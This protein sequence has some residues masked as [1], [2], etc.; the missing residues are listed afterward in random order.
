MHTD[1]N[2]DDGDLYSRT[3]YTTDKERH[4]RQGASEEKVQ[5]R[6][7]ADGVYSSAMTDLS[8][9][10]VSSKNVTQKDF[11]LQS[12][13][14]TEMSSCHLNDEKTFAKINTEN[15]FD[16][17]ECD[18]ETETGEE[19]DY[20]HLVSVVE[21]DIKNISNRISTAVIDFSFSCQEKGEENGSHCNH[22]DFVP[23]EIILKIFSYFDPLDLCKQIS[24]VSKRWRKLAYDVSLW[25]LLDLNWNPHL[26][27]VNLCWIIKR[28]GCIRK[29]CLQSRQMLSVSEVSVFTEFCPL[30]TDVDLG[31]CSTCSADILE[32]FVLNCENLERINVEGCHMVADECCEVLAKAKRLKHLNFSHCIITDAGLCHLA[33]NLSQIVSLN[34]DGIGW[35]NDKS[36]ITLVEHHHENLKWLD[37]DGAELT[38]RSIEAVAGCSGLE[39]LTVSFCELLTDTSLREVS[40]MTKLNC[41]SLRKGTELTNAGVVELFSTDAMSN[42]T[43]LDLSDCGDLKDSAVLQILKC[44]GRNLRQL[45]LCWCCSLQEESVTAIVDTCSSLE[46]LDLVGL[47]K[48][49]GKCFDRIPKC[50]PKLTL[51]DLRQCNKIN[52]NLIREMLCK[53]SDLKAFDYYGE[54]FRIQ[55]QS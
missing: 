32:Y 24:L 8:T 26:S 9:V 3:D 31:F 18:K 27:S 54:D 23:N 47:H 6:H 5:F 20:T 19:V 34:I 11:T 13:M 53:K 44:C 2:S 4:C 12:D 22:F 35:I 21:N 1:T 38:D 52:D 37:I 50:M 36:M 33:R 41:L 49:F 42:L 15:S 55:L 39:R 46:T 40:K 25:T 14:N 17:Y 51:L 28:L 10:S 43:C 16:H 45:R 29:L 7:G 48:I 30:L